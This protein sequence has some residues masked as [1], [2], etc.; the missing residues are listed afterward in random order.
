MRT[1]VWSMRIGFTLLFIVLL[2]VTVWA[3]VS[4]Q[5]PPRV[6]VEIKTKTEILGAAYKLYA[7]ENLGLWL[8]RVVIH[9]RG[10]GAITQVRIRY[11]MGDLMEPAEHTIDLIL[12]DQKVVDFYFPII[13]ESITQET[14]GR[15]LPLRI[16]ITYTQRNGRTVQKREERP[17]K[18]MGRNYL[19][20]S[21][22]PQDELLTWHDM[23]SNWFL[24]N[25][26]ITPNEETTKY[27]A[28]QCAGGLNTSTD[29]RDR[30]QAWARIYYCLR[31]YGVKYFQ[32]PS[33][34]W[35]PHFNQYVQFPKETLQRKGGTCLDLAILFASMAQA[36]GI[37]AGVALI[38]GHAIPYIRLSN[39]EYVFVESTI[40][41]RQYAISHFADVVSRKVTF[42]EA[43]QLATAQIQQAA[44]KGQ[45]ILVDYNQLRQVGVVSPW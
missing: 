18:V 19:V 41:D 27:A 9:N 34:N 20:W 10:P 28:I 30:I 4:V 7:D 2:G 16:E 25:V 35:T 15:S 33:D 22:M 31:Q 39:G 23:F 14:S 1:L 21:S 45:I 40:V 38:P 37:E 6:I 3:W 43:Y 36:L 32:E 44:Q 24:V 17:I 12:P 8:A 29:D 11:S 5:T 26:F 13:H 42:E